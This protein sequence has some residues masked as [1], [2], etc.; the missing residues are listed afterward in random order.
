MATTHILVELLFDFETV[1]HLASMGNSTFHALVCV[2][3]YGDMFLGYSIVPQHLPESL[4]VHTVKRL[5][6][7]DEVDIKRGLPLQ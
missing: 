7:C 2:T 5:L 1:I 3:N 6:I 4:S